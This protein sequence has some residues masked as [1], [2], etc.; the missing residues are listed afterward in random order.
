M[1]ATRSCGVVMTVVAALVLVSGCAL[2]LGV[3]G[4]FSGY[5]L[6]RTPAV[7]QNAPA[8]DEGKLPVE[9]PPVE[10]P[11][12]EK[13]PVEKVPVEK[14]PVEKPPVEKPPV[15]K[16]PVEKP[17]ILPLDPPAK[18]DIFKR[19]L[20]IIALN[21]PASRIED[22]LF[23]GGAH[24]KFG[25]QCNRANFKDATHQ[26]H[27][28]DPENQQVI[29]TDLP[30]PNFGPC[31]RSLAP[32]GRYIAMETR[33]NAI[34]ISIWAVGNGEPIL[35]DWSLP[36][37]AANPSGLH[38]GFTLLDKDR[39]LTVTANGTFEWWQLPDMNSIRK[40][41][42]PGN[43]VNA[44]PTF[45]P[46]RKRCALYHRDHFHIIDLEKAFTICE[47]PVVPTL[48]GRPAVYSS[49]GS[50]AFSPDNTKLAAVLTNAAPELAAFCYDT[51]TGNQ[52]GP[53]APR[54]RDDRALG[55]HAGWFGPHHFF[56]HDHFRDG[57]VNV[58]RVG[59]DAP[60]AVLSFS[61]KNAVVGTHSP[62]DRLWYCP[63]SEAG[64][65][66]AKI[67][68]TRLTR[69]IAEAVAAQH[70]LLRLS[71]KGLR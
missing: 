34:R 26:F 70:T 43:L 62:D 28:I 17:P 20:I 64:D 41:Q 27:V 23:T 24:P 45:S 3:G 11:P 25:I 50:V 32:D 12:V 55:F 8:R 10:K 4:V 71:A 48:P 33:T 60:S 69:P 49:F 37:T 6:G 56:L 19:E 67:I 65:T 38:R 46:D 53:V 57:P 40:F 35:R 42:A 58:Y 22:I 61:A 2:C 7:A 52:V 15:E 9:K 63:P 14:P 1:P 16:P 29:T 31:R 59:D 66:G 47:T 30:M 68:G 36:P 18:T 39:L 21:V 51:T 54:P 44:M 13:P 5:Y